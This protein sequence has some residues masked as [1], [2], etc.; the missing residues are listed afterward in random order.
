[1]DDDSVLVDIDTPE[2]LAALAE[3]GRGMSVDTAALRAEFPIFAR[4]PTRPST[5]WTTRRPARSA[6]AAADALWRYETTHR[7][8]V[9]ARRLPARPTPRRPPSSRRA[10]RSRAYLGAA[11]AGRGRSSRGGTTLGHQ[12]R[13]PRARRPARPGRRD[14][15]PSSSITPTSCPGRSRRERVGRRDPGAAGDR[16][17]PA[18]SRPARQLVTPTRRLD[19]RRPTRRTSPARSRISAGS[20]GGA[21]GRRHGAASTARSAAPHGPIDVQAL[22]CDFYAFSG[23]KMFGA[24]RGRRAVGAQ[25]PAGRAAALPR[26]RRDDPRGDASSGTTYAAPPHRFEA[27]TPPIGPAIGMGAAA[28]WLTTLD[29]DVVARHEM[30]LTE[31]DARRA[32]GLPA[33]RVV[34]PRGLQGRIGVV[35]FEVE[36]V[37]AHDVCQMLDGRGRVPARRPP[38][39][40]AA[41]GALRPRRPRRGRASRP[42]MIRMMSTP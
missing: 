36:G 5:I 24:D 27:G 6:A 3:Q 26:R 33:V 23:H 1:M 14:P 18:R 12:Y 25:G 11:D 20:R 34:G 21:R 28:A 22:G 4:Q 10:A 39:R 31:R 13:R 17:G 32:G 19:R 35:S 2:A 8:N 42:T 41:D 9:Q 38:L 7:A 15:A 40:A 37:H 29:W 30:A 16:G